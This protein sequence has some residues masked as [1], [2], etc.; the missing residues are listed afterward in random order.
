MRPWLPYQLLVVALAAWSC[1]Q[2][3]APRAEHGGRADSSAQSAVRLGRASCPDDSAR[4]AAG[5]T[6][7]SFATER[8]AF[9]LAPHGA[10]RSDKRLTVGLADSPAI[11]VDC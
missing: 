10:S 11:L 6:D 8:E 4:S 9:R 3:G 5:M 2:N 1:G 7:A